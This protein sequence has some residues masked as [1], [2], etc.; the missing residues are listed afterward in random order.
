MR[1][2]LPSTFIAAMR[3]SGHRL[4]IE[5]E[6]N[7]YPTPRRARADWFCPA[8]RRR[9]DLDVEE[10]VRRRPTKN[11]SE[12]CASPTALIPQT[13]GLAARRSSAQGDVSAQRPRRFSETPL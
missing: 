1:P 13:P 11:Y 10:D 3:G 7:S 9:K 8:T 5:P 2:R 12:W 4:F 6:R